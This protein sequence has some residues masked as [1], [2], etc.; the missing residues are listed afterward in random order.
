MIGLCLDGWAHRY[1]PEL[2]SFFTPWHAVFYSGFIAGTSWLAYMVIRRRPRTSSL[3]E[4]IP[5]GYGISVIGLAMF[6]V[7]GVGDGF[8]HT[9]FGVETGIDALL[10]PTHLLLLAG[11]LGGAVAP[12]RSAWNNPANPFAG[13]SFSGFLPVALS[14]A[15]ATTGVA[16]FFLYANGFSNWQTQ[17]R[18]IPNS[19]DIL[20]A[21]GI[22]S[23]LA[24]TVILIGPTMLL[25]RRWQPPFGTFLLIFGT[26]GFFMAG[27]DAYEYWW[28]VF[29]PLTGGLV[30]DLIVRSQSGSSYNNRTAWLVGALVPLAM[31]SVSTVAIHIAW[32]IRWPPELW[33]GQI[34]MATLAGFAIAL[35]S[36]PPAVPAG[37][38]APG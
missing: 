26:V 33:A 7:G 36:H 17:N 21:S 2:E 31:W 8:W 20:A 4:A 13:N 23:T 29:A 30:A 10:S 14:V 28:Q 3:R 24:S 25:L 35:I 9:I 18:Y 5:P 34:I 1:Q 11:M 32:T 22:L 16:F 27:L 37:V 12:V 15:I 38:A 19:G 6:A